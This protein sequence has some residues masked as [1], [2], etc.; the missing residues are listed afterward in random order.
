[1]SKPTYTIKTRNPLS[2]YT[3]K[4]IKRTVVLA[5][6]HKAMTEE[7]AKPQ[8]RGLQIILLKLD[9]KISN[10]SNVINYL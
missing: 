10:K 4:V 6:A 5:T 9:R 3:S 2:G 1:M 8:N 7:R